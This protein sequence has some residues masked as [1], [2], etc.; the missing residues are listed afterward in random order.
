MLQDNLIKNKL[1]NLFQDSLMEQFA[2]QAGDFRFRILADEFETHVVKNEKG[3]TTKVIETTFHYFDVKVASVLPSVFDNDFE[4]LNQ[5]R[6][7]I[8][9]II[10]NKGG[11]IV[12]LTGTPTNYFV[13]LKVEFKSDGY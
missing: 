3:Q 2:H 4:R 6:S 13:Y 12:K 9:S 1:Y 8:T 11:R 10:K 7:E 5:I